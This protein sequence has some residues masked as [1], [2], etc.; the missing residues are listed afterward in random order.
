MLLRPWRADDAMA[1]LPVLEANRDHLEPWIPKRVSEPAPIGILEERLAGCGQDFAADREWRFGM[2]LLD[3]PVPLGEFGLFPRSA[4]G[5][6]PFAI[7]DRAEIGYWLRSDFTGRGL[8]NEAARAV[9][10]AAAAVPRFSHI[11]IRC[12]ARNAPSVAVARRLGFT[13]ASASHPDELG[14]NSRATLQIW[15]FPNRPGG[16]R[17]DLARSS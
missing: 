15:T 10:G 7:S 14:D 12:D 6:V 11:E 16:Q 8:V 5:R 13:L 4:S 3:Q 9:L 17:P 2:F 1:V